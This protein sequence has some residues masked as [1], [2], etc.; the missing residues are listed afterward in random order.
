MYMIYK[1]E[2][3]LSIGLKLYSM[4]VVTN[5]HVRTKFLTKFEFNETSNFCVY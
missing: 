2:D 1:T 3:I 4:I 5:A